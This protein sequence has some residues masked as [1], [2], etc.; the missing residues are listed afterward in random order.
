MAPATTAILV[1]HLLVAEGVGLFGVTSLALPTGTDEPQAFPVPIPGSPTALL[2]GRICG[3]RAVGIGT[4][5]ARDLWH[6]SSLNTE[7]PLDAW[8]GRWLL[9]NWDRAVGGADHGRSGPE[10]V[11]VALA[12]LRHP[13]HHMA[14]LGALRL[15][16][17]WIGRIPDA[18]AAAL[19][20]SA[21]AM[22]EADAA[23]WDP[24][25]SQVPAW[26]HRSNGP[27]NSELVI[28]A[29][30]DLIARIPNA[31]RWDEI[32]ETLTTVMG[33]VHQARPTR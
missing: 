15:I 10:V 33:M 28:T 12:G 30:G 22:A 11:A 25:L 24:V 9:G 29:I 17:G 3:L 1:G 7:V 5:D 18:D 13:G 2:L 23:W 8:S 6:P 32:R 16:A 20:R 14:R 31:P 19:I 27:E 4:R 21:T 26:I